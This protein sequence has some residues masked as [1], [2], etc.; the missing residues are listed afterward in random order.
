MPS[1]QAPTKDMQFVLHDVLNVTE[2]GIPGYDELEA[3]FTSPVLE[4]AGHERHRLVP[5]SY[6]DYQ[7]ACRNELPER[8]MQAQM[9]FR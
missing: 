8:I 5:C 2:S 9:R 6:S 7:D 1:Y 3:D 4:E